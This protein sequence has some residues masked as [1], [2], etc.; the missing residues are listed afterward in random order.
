[1]HNNIVKQF[2]TDVIGKMVIHY[3][4]IDSTQKEV[5]RRIEENNIENGTVI[6]A[7]I[8]TDGIGTHGRKWYTTEKQ[9]IAF[10]FVTFPNVEV[11]K[12][13]NLT[14]KIAKILVSIFENT[15]HIKLE[16]KK[17]ND[18]MIKGK[19]VGGIL[20]QTKLQGEI[21]KNLVI[22]IGINTN[23]SNFDEEIET[24]ATSVKKEFGIIVDNNRVIQEFIY[25]FEKIMKNMICSL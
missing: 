15:Y 3:E 19:K 16:I 1:M 12:L 7:D 17:P 21:V 9:N 5:W 23:Q 14:T 25:K 4:K 13:E 24:I 11:K 2:D 22:G 10:S 18:L 20:T 8:Q 6:I